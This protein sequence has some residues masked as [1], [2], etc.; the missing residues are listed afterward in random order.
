MT[1]SPD[2]AELRYRRA[3]CG[4][5]TT[6]VDGEI[7]DVNDLFA[8]WVGR[9]AAELAGE[10]FVTL[11]DASSRLFYETRHAQVLQLEGRVSEVAVSLRHGDGTAVPVLLSAAI[12]VVGG[13]PLVRVAVFSAANRIAY[14]EELVR[15]RRAAETSEARLRVLQDVSGA[16]G[17]SANDDEVV[18]SFVTAA[19]SAFAAA[20]V[21][22]HLFDDDGVLQLAAGSNPLLGIVAPI[23]ELQHT[24][25]EVVLTA[26]EADAVYPQLAAGLRGIRRAAISVLPLVTDGAHLGVLVCYFGRARAFDEDFRDLQRALGR[27]AAQTLVRVRLQRRLEELARTDSLTRVANRQTIEQSLDEAIDHAR[28]GSGPLALVFLDLDDFKAVNDTYGHPAGDDVL[29]TLAQRVSAAVRA[30]DT[31]GRIGGD[32]FVVLC[33]DADVAAATLIADRIR[34]VA[35]EPIAT[36]AGTVTVSVS[37]GVAVHDPDDAVRPTPDQLLIRA[38]A[39]MYVSKESGKDRVSVAEPRTPPPAGPRATNLGG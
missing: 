38:D 7:L 31:V 2:D 18:D 33:R 13:T 12:D 21:A 17:A 27:Q 10:R 14:E 20:E 29:R 25:R 19:R 39:A 22:V 35:R 6:R 4:L 24:A 11:L 36:S 34:V 3:P 1:A 5:L 23:P 37:I 28:S 32:E 9:P 15:A 26:D 8:Q 16:F 30:D